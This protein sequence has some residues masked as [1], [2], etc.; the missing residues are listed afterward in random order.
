MDLAWFL[1]EPTTLQITYQAP[2]W[3]WASTEGC[4]HY[5][6]QLYMKAKAS[7]VRV[8]TVSAGKDPL[9]EVTAGMLVIKGPCLPAL[10]ESEVARGN[11]SAQNFLSV[12]DK[13]APVKMNWQQDHENSNLEDQN[14]TAVLVASDNWL[15]HAY[16]LVLL[17]ID[18][19]NQVYHRVGLTV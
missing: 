9:G 17:H 16:Y 2:S 12:I 4:V 5:G 3:S 14:L 13:N 11:R 18:K 10:V 6:F 7:V 15:F 8:E 1:V 19:D